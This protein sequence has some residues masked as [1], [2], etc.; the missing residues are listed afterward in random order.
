[1]ENRC[2]CGVV[3][4]AVVELVGILWRYG[5]LG[6]LVDGGRFGGNDWLEGSCCWVEGRWGD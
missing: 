6:A 4:E 2:G 1:M 5:D 3:I